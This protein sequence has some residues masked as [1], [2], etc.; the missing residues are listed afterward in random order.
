[1]T[2]PPEHA[3]PGGVGR[4]DLAL[5]LLRAAVE[6]RA[7]IDRVAEIELVHRD[8]SALLVERGPLEWVVTVVDGR[9]EGFLQGEELTDK[10]AQE[11]EAALPT[12]VAELTSWSRRQ[13]ATLVQALLAASWTPEAADKKSV[14]VI[15]DEPIFLEGLE[16]LLRRRFDVTATTSPKGALMLAR[17]RPFD[18]IFV[19]ARMPEMDGLEWQHTLGVTHP[20]LTERTVLMTACERV[21]A[22][23]LPRVLRKPFGYPELQAYL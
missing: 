16:R 22:L 15:D 1:M 14:L 6:A 8:G 11:Y 2:F 20:H 13:A 10:Q 4:D 18:R 21:L 9:L 17:L 12:S 3:P 19:D 7:E 5:Q 23:E